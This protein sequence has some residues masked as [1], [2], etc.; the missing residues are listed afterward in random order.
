[1]PQFG[2]ATTPYS[3]GTPT[4]S[5]TWG[6]LLVALETAIS[7]TNLLSH[8][9]PVGYSAVPSVS[10]GCLSSSRAL[11]SNAP[12]SSLP[13]PVMGRWS[14]TTYRRGRASR[15]VI[16]RQFRWRARR[17]RSCGAGL[18]ATFVAQMSQIRKVCFDRDDYGVS[19]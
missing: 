2:C 9:P 16:S 5:L 17:L 8:C 12:R 14:T 18:A 10:G 11:R 1:V 3:G 4:S 6:V 7:M 13:D 15:G 19:R